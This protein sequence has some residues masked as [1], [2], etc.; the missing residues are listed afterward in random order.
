VFV[1]IR[2]DLLESA[3]RATDQSCHPAVEAGSGVD[4]DVPGTGA[5]RKAIRRND[6]L[7]KGG[8]RR[9]RP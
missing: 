9:R 3:N 7:E 2:D 6:R 5:R 4:D 1:S 8:R